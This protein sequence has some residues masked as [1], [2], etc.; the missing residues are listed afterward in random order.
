MPKRKSRGHGISKRLGRT[1][2]S[3][4]KHALDETMSFTGGIAEKK[5]RGGTTKRPSDWSNH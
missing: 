4:G 5:K 3:L 1:V 2:T